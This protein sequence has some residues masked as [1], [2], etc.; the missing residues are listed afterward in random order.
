MH[1][2]I[3][4]LGL[5]TVLFTLNACFK[6]EKVDI[7]IHNAK[8][9]TMDQEGTIAEAIAIHEGVII[10]VG[11]EREILNRFRADKFINAQKK[12][13]IPGFHD[14][15]GHI[16][17]YAKQKMVANL[18]DATSY[19]D[20]L[21]RVE[22]FHEKNP[23]EFIVGRGWDQSLWDVDTFPTNALLNERFPDIPVALTRV[24]GH[25]M[26]VNDVLLQLTGLDTMASIAGGEVVR[27]NGKPTGLLLDNA[28][29]IVTAIV[30]KPNKEQLTAKIKEVEQELFS[31]GITHVHEAG[32]YADDRD[33]LLELYADGILQLNTYLM[34]FP[35]A[36]NKRFIRENGKVKEGNLSI[37]SMKVMLDGALGSHGACML[38]PYS[39][40]VH[41]QG[42]RLI[43]DSTLHEVAAF[44]VEQGY[45]L[46]AHCI[47]DSANRTMLDC[48]LKHVKGESDHRWRIEHAQVV[49]PDDMERFDLSGIIPSIQPTH[50]TSDYRW[51][52]KHIGSERLTGAY[53]YKTLLNMRNMMVIGTDFPIEAIDPFATIHAA[54]QRKN[55]DNEPTGG[56]L[57]EEAL[58]LAETLRGMTIWSA[59]GCFEEATV[60]SIEKGKRANIAI[61]DYPLVSKPVFEPNYAYC[62]MIDG[63]IVYSQE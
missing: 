48:A 26:L 59:Y 33:L 11:P 51:A 3:H 19:Y 50:A 27:N 42:L 63:G 36:E 41:S 23:S 53:A 44:A 9:H 55:T 57:M 49:H 17:S 43:D 60:G 4:L 61:L 22:E 38:S 2:R 6:G 25:S 10:A 37:R 15:H 54:V 1:K 24:D 12:D 18:Y 58:T 21:M 34:L 13:V 30:P 45:Q 62:T 14:G 32:V 20:M 35:S 56:F 40:L 39:D 47:G 5:L 29:D 7:I 16:M 28:I 8:V 31:Y 52:E 46:N